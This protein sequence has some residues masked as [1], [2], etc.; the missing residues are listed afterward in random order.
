MCL[1]RGARVIVRGLGMNQRLFDFCG[2]QQ[3]ESVF[4]DILVLTLSS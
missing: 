2:R 3:W 4:S 1:R